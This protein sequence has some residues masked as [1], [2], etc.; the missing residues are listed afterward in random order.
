MTEKQESSGV[1]FCLSW[2]WLPISDSYFMNGT[3]LMSRC[4]TL[5]GLS[6][7][8]DEAGVSEVTEQETFL[9]WS[10]QEM[11]VFLQVSGSGTGR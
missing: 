2:E 1:G 10:K 6:W 3:A 11:L 5:S 4:F 8:G 7:W 9:L